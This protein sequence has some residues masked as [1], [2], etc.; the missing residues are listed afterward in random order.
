MKK[1]FDDFLSDEG[2][3]AGAEGGGM[4]MDAMAGMFEEDME[5]PL[6]SALEG[7]GYAGVS[8]DKL[9]QIRAILEEPGGE[10]ETGETEGA[11]EGAGVAP[12]GMSV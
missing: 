2:G 10:D 11:G 6:I 3:G 5:D 12:K 9:S 1:A 7:A 4:N 8:P